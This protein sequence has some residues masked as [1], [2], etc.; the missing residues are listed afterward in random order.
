VLKIFV[1]TEEPDGFKTDRGHKTK[2]ISENTSL[3]SPP[4]SPYSEP[5]WNTNWNHLFI[6]FKELL[7]NV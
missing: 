3:P 2:H 6:F 5:Q 7:P 1:G 4:P